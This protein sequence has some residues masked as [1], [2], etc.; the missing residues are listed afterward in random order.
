[1]HFIHPLP[2]KIKNNIHV[3]YKRSIREELS[4]EHHTCMFNKNDDPFPEDQIES[5]N[6]INKLNNHNKLN[7]IK[8][9]NKRN[10]INK[11]DD[12][13]I[14]IEIAVFADYLMIKH[15]Y[16][17]YGKENHMKELKRFII[18]TVNNVD[19]LYR[20]QTL[21]SNIH[22]RLKRID[23]MESQPSELESIKHDNGDVNKLLKSFCEYQHKMKPVER[24][25]PRYWDH[26]LLF[27]GFDIYSGDIKSIAGFAP[28]K[29]M[30]SEVRSCTIN[31][32]IDFGSVFVV[33]HEIGHN[34]G[35][36]H[37]G[38]NECHTDCCI[39][40][41]SIGS[42]KTEW[43]TC[44]STE[45]KVFVQ[46]LGTE[47]NRAPN[48]LKVSAKK[49]KNL[50]TLPG[51]D[52]TINEQCR[53]FHGKCWRHGLR[54]HQKLENICQMIWCTDDN[55]KFRTS[56]P[57][58]EGTY[59]GEGKICFGGKCVE[60]KMDLKKI[61]GGWGDWLE[62]PYCG[63]IE[64]NKCEKCQIDGQLIF[65]KEYRYC[66]N[67]FPNNGG[68]LCVGDD[69]RGK[70]CN[71]RL[72]SSDIS[73]QQYIDNVCKIKSKLPKNIILKMTEKGLHFEKDLCKVWCFIKEST[74]IKTVEDMPNGTP[75]GKDS[76]C[77]NGECKS[78]TCN[79]TILG[80]DNND[81]N[82]MKNKNLKSPIMTSEWE[83]WLSWSNCSV[84]KCGEIGYKRR[85]R[86]CKGSSCSGQDFEEAKCKINCLISE[87]IWLNWGE[88]S[89]CS[90]SQCG[91]KGKQVRTRKCSGEKCNGS[92]IESQ[93]CQ[94][95]CLKNNGKFTTWSS[96]S[97][98]SPIIDCKTE[99]F[100]KRT[101]DCW[102]A[103]SHDPTC[104]GKK[105]EIELC[106]RTKC[107]K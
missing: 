42:G 71:E 31:E 53:L 44:S 68:K 28:V 97:E 25:D 23:V 75:C 89:E 10:A 30:C 67:P 4:P 76:F 100:R 2:K 62:N 47:P 6:L 7:F 20:H 56:H 104:N 90:S 78:L 106:P 98:C 22:F 57:A 59:C 102:S 101:R 105:E 8:N 55:E 74:S 51:Q 5:N 14:T 17:I 32:G 81:C 91:E 95:I 3:I 39:M 80:G 66:E 93:I 69:I 73:I 88:W 36:Y 41:P 61:D 50:N 12:S 24:K 29:G 77:L 33:T 79:G 99:T 63:Q 27:T 83:S 103:T 85:I 87:N 37:D 84:K 26:A 15:F 92:E 45:M 72:C 34:L 60:T 13:E 43:S 1:M 18:A 16:D 94:I 96:W 82:L 64:S 86:I 107:I 9:I 58:L 21:N 48:C 70:V 38:Q 49:S 35:M 52:Y 40:A 46:K 65:K 11:E 19:S 54:S